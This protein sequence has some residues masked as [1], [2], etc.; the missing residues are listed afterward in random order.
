MK[1]G[2]QPDIFHSLRRSFEFASENEFSHVEILMDHPNFYHENIGFA[3]ILELRGSYDVDVLIHASAT[4]TN[5]IS[6]SPHMRKASYREL[7]K[8]LIFAHKCEAELVTFHIGWNPGF[9]T[10][11]GFVYT[12]DWYSEHNFKVL[13]DEMYAFL[14]NVNS[15]ILALENTIEMD[16]RMQKAIEHLIK[17]TDL[18]LTFDIG[19]YSVK[20]SHSIFLKYFDRVENVHL[21]D[22]RGEYDEHLPLGRGNIDLNIIPFEKYN[23]F[24]TLELRDERAILESKA[25]LTRYISN[26]FKQSDKSNLIVDGG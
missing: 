25:Y 18:K 1:L 9:I 24:L 23:G 19:H 6:I 13:T 21:H 20:S 3:Q 16:E 10:S 26:Y 4:A 22:N 8:T 5:F 7:E 2:T 12:N 11:N 17:N 15:E 14:K